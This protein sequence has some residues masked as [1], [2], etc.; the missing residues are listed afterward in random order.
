MS[1][2]TL[3]APS[4]RLCTGRSIAAPGADDPSSIPTDNIDEIVA[5]YAAA[6]PRYGTEFLVG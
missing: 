3:I 5:R 4:P 6:A 2:T 1:T